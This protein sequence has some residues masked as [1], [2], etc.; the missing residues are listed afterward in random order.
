[1]IACDEYN[2]YINDWDSLRRTIAE[3]NYSKVLVVVDENTKL[4]CLPTLQRELQVELHCIEIAAGEESKTIATCQHIWQQ[5]IALGADRHSLCINLGGG[6]I[7]DM[8]GFA[9]ATYM[10]GMAFI[11]VP[12]T[13]L[14]QV[15]ASVGGKLGVDHQ[16]YKNIIGLIKTPVAVC[17]HT[18][19]LSTL[20]YRE[21][22]S[23]YAELIK[24]GLIADAGEYTYLQSIADLTTVEWQPIVERSVKLKQTITDQDPNE[25]GLR[26]I[27]NFGHTI[28]HAIESYCLGGPHHLLHGE[29]IAIGMIVEAH[30]SHQL[31]Y[32]TLAECDHIRS[33]ISTLYGHHTAGLPPMKAMVDNMLKD[34]K[35]RSGQIRYSLLAAIGEGNYDQVVGIEVVEQAMEYY[36]TPK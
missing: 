22:R 16:S 30:M 14:S 21:L 35:N 29:A 4:H 3:H 32:L 8:G 36:K 2:I 24:H 6:V 31:G 15:D 27:L 20:P 19:M 7:G 33:Y 26:K 34:K 23:G 28:G 10:R 5:M 12:T 9:A 13:L 1:M 18:D 17:I 25:K 11:Q